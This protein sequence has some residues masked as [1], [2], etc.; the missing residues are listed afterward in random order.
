M[1]NY[2]QKSWI[3][4]IIS[5]KV[6]HDKVFGVN[7]DSPKKYQVNSGNIIHEVENAKN[8]GLHRLSNSAYAIFV[9]YQNINE[10]GIAKIN[11]LRSGLS[12]QYSHT[13]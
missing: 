7:I 12:F 9:A 8:L 6:Q 1:I 13:N 11:T 3:K 5:A 2:L 10:V 4:M